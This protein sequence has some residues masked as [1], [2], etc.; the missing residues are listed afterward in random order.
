MIYVLVFLGGTCGGLEEIIKRLDL[1]RG[2]GRNEV[3]KSNRSASEY[4]NNSI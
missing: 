1:G 2:T 3:L 4:L